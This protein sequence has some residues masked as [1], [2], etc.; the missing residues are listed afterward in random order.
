M[1]ATRW[2]R[3]TPGVSKSSPPEEKALSA[4]VP[5]VVPGMADSVGRVRAA[6][7]AEGSKWRL[8][9][10]FISPRSALTK[11]LFP[12]LAAP[13]TYTS[14]PRRSERM[15]AAASLMPLPV[16][17]L[18]RCTPTTL[19]RLRSVSPQSHSTTSASE[20]PLGRRSTLVAMS[21][22]G[23]RPTRSR[24]RLRKDPLT[25]SR[26]TTLTTTAFFSRTPASCLRSSSG[27]ISRRTSAT[28]MFAP[29]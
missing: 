18:T 13:S 25:S 9:K 7:V 10:D 20:V 14:L 5:R 3:C 11:A 21:T 27:L 4:M 19:S 17:L 12:T 28:P 2:W 23:L 22:M 16:L 26:S 8:E 29:S 24:T 1:C 15:P 6:L